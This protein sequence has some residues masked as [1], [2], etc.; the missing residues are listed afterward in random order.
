MEQAHVAQDD[1][2]TLL[3][4]VRS[5]EEEGIHPQIEPPPEEL[6]ANPPPIYIDGHLHLVEN[7]VFTAFD[8]SS[9]RDPK[10]WVLDTGASNHMTGARTAFADLDFGITGSVRFGDG[11][12]AQIEGI[13]TV[14]FSCKNGEHR[15]L[16]NVYYLPRLTANIVSVGQLDEDGYQVLLEHGVMRV[17]DEERRLLAKIHRS[18]GR[19]YV[20]DITIA[21]PVC[22]AARGEDDAWIWHA[23]FGHLCWGIQENPSPSKR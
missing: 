15:V 19:L 8:D 17:R 2:P 12:V 18:P 23:R 21:R 10:R 22:L 16:P 4:A 20:F 3:L 5:E 7:R 11:S 1:E 9:N 13:G 6:P 14:L